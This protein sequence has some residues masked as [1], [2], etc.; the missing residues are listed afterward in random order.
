ML[1][2]LAWHQVEYLAHAV[3]RAVDHA[4]A[5]KVLVRI[6]PVQIQPK[7]VHHRVPRDPVPVILD[8]R[9]I[10]FCQSVAVK[11][12]FGLARLR[13]KIVHL[14]IVSGNTHVGRA[15]RIHHGDALH[16]AV[17]YIE[18]SGHFLYAHSIAR[19]L[20]SKVYH[21]SY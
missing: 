3:D 10:E 16:V 4:Q 7:A 13:R 8:R 9:R 5:A 11:L 21:S 2:G 18:Y 12:R 14:V 15:E 19:D 17:C 20:G 1:F 6:V